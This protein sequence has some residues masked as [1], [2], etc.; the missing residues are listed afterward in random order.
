MVL[1]EQQK[2][3]SSSLALSQRKYNGPEQKQE[4]YIRQDLWPVMIPADEGTN[5]TN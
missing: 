3:K 1:G 2:V 4:A 5:G